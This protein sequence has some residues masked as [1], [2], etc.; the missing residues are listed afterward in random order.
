MAHEHHHHHGELHYIGA[1][2]APPTL[3]TLRAARPE[4]AR[5][6]ELCARFA[7]LTTEEKAELLVAQTQVEQSVSWVPGYHSPGDSCVSCGAGT[8]ALFADRYEEGELPYAAFLGGLPV[9]PT[10]ACLA[11]APRGLAPNKLDQARR[12]VMKDLNR[13]SPGMSMFFRH[14]VLAHPPFGLEDWANSVA[15]QNDGKLDRATM[16]DMDRLL[17]WVHARLYH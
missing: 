11:K 12:K 2:V 4:L 8:V 9:H 13:P 10:E 16:R 15:E 6:L 3:E 1:D 17:S 14:D 7:D 5:N